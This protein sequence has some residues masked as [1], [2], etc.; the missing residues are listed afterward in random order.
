MAT[1]QTAAL[2]AYL[3]LWG[4]ITG[5]TVAFMLRQT[6][7]EIELTHTYAAEGL[8]PELLRS[9]EKRRVWADELAE[10]FMRSTK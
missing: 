6:A 1:T 10:H 2:A 8:P 9:L 4:P 5:L 3:A 7:T